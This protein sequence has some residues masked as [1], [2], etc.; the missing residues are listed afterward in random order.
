MCFITAGMGGGTGTGAAPI[1]A[2]AA[3]EMGIPDR[4]R[5]DQA[6]PVRGLQAHA[7]GRGGVEA[8]QKV[9]TLIIIPNQKPVPGWPMKRPPSPKLSPWPMTCCIRRQGRGLTH[10]AA[11]SHQLDFADVRAVMDEMGKAMMGTG[12]ASGENRAVQAA[13]ALVAEPAAG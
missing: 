5:G 4:R 11:G 2:Q 3:R 13:R 10:G 9:V 12:E 8:L 1:I 7:S 6:L